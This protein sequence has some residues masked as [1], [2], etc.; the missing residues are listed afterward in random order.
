MRSMWKGFVSFG[1]V[2]IPVKLYSATESK[3]GI[4]LNLIHSKDDGKIHYRRVCDKCG[5]EVE[6][7]DVGRGYKVGE[8]QYVE[9][10]EEDFAKAD[11]GGSQTIDIL[12]FT[13]VEDVD[14]KMFERPYFLEPQ[15][16]SERPYALL[17][18]ALKK[19]KRVGIA[20]VVLRDKQH[21]ACIKPEGDVLLLEM[22]R[23]PDELRSA[24]ELKLPSAKEARDRE[25]DL[26]GELIDRMT[27][28][29]DPA[30]YKDE[31]QEQLEQIIQEKVAGVEPVPRGEAPSATKVVDIMDV[32]RRSLA[33]RKEGG[34]TDTA[35]KRERKP[36]RE[37]PRA[38]KPRTRKRAG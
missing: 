9:I 19:K 25:L 6:W 26:A 36:P 17:R 8:D 11:V 13:G 37:K 3:E 27:V 4:H 32:L 14:L 35:A 38:R 30:R 18:E 21:L 5:E 33:D 31:Y 15:K 28:E 20:K 10:T 29:F 7:K 12:D 2:T 1:L 16:G 24:E 22:L 23:F 34:G